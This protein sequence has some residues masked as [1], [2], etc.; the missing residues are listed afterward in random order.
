V[1]S[2]N[3]ALSDIGLSYEPDVLARAQA[4]DSDAFCELCRPYEDRLFRQALAL[5]GDHAIA[6]DLAQ[7]TL[8]QAWKSLRRFNGRCRLFTW[9]CSIML[10]RYQKLIR[11]KRAL[12]VSDEALDAVA[13]QLPSPAATSESNERAVLLQRHLDTLPHKQRQ[14]LYL[15]F[16]VDNSLEQIAAAL[17]CSVGTVKSR[18]FHGL[19]N[20]RKMRSLKQLDF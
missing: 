5:C 19:E 17:A 9:F 2:L 11:R 8:L 13:D 14:V 10:H 1:Q 4:R 7:E 18:L 3:P 20:L 6:Q 15:R 16:Y 12:L